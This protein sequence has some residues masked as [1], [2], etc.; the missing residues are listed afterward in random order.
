VE[1]CFDEL[2][3]SDLESFRSLVK[4]DYEHHALWVKPSVNF[5][6]KRYKVDEEGDLLYKEDIVMQEVCKQLSGLYNKFEPRPPKQ[7]DMLHVGM[8]QLVERPGSP[9]IG[10][11]SFIRGEYHKWNTNTGWKDEST[12]R[13]TPHAFSF[14][15]FRVTRGEMMVVDIQGVGDLYTDPQ[16]HTLDGEGFGKGNLGARGMALFLR[17]FRFDQNPVVQY[18]QLTAFAL[19][20]GELCPPSTAE[21]EKFE[22][23]LAYLA[24]KQ[25]EKRMQRSDTANSVVETNQ[26]IVEEAS[27]ITRSS[28]SR[29]R[30]S[31]IDDTISEVT[32]TSSSFAD[33]LNEIP[34]FLLEVRN[35]YD[36][37][38]CPKSMRDTIPLYESPEAA[39]HLALAKLYEE[40]DDRVL[41]DIDQELFD[42]DYTI[43]FHKWMAALGGSV[44]AMVEC[45]LD[46]GSSPVTSL[47]WFQ[48]A[49]ERGSRCACLQAL[50]LVDPSDA[51]LC[52]YYLQL[53][54]EVSDGKT[55]AER[56]LDME[57]CS[58]ELEAELGDAFLKLGETEN[59]SAHLS[60][61]AELAMEAGQFKLYEQ[62]LAKQSSI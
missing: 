55:D 21:I 16:V 44:S 18:M 58:Y 17:S 2:S 30:N 9:Y 25:W 32:T 19:A 38:E 12:F 8:L 24:S 49:A 53:A 35:S 14:A 36:L 54:L 52:I 15:T 4:K 45:G 48:L 43:R 1:Q 46:Q 57:K 40:N 62:Y 5:M 50:S 41:E 47:A 6:G 42:L 20:P 23:G 60:K 59:A 3:D 61:A 27:R 56:K 13:H 11:E 7:I 22:S 33:K 28:S 34:S 29:R 31:T 10:Y 51:L 26:N 39:I 37:P